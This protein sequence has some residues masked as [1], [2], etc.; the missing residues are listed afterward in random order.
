[1]RE[2][3]GAMAAADVFGAVVVLVEVVYTSRLPAF[4][5]VKE[6]G[7]SSFLGCAR[8]VGC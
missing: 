8:G 2:E 1:M 6:G 3:E 5:G 4:G 7:G